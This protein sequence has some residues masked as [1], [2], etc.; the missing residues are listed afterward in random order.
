MSKEHESESFETLLKKTRNHSFG[1]VVKG[2]VASGNYF[3]LKEFV[4]LLF[5]QS[6][7]IVYLIPSFLVWVCTP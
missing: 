4:I 7:G 1:Q 5:I 3:L 2:R 6:L